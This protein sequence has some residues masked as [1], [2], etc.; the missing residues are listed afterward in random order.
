MA[1][2]DHPYELGIGFQTASNKAAVS[3][4]VASFGRHAS[5]NRPVASQLTRASSPAANRAAAVYNQKPRGSPRSCLLGIEQ[6]R[7]ATPRER[8][9]GNAPSTPGVPEPAKCS[10]GAGYGLAGTDSGSNLARVALKVRIRGDSGY[11]SSSIV[12][13][14]RS[15]RP[16]FSSLDS[17]FSWSPTIALTAKPPGESPH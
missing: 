9:P 8:N 16:N 15:A 14:S 12:R 13:L 17:Q 3:L 6:T 2:S 7:I 1:A 5:V 11:R 10:F 4:P